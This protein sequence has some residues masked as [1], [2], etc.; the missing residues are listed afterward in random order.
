MSERKKPCPGQ[1][2]SQRGLTVNKM[3]VELG[4][5]PR[6]KS[7]GLQGAQLHAI[8]MTSPPL[9]ATLPAP[10]VSGNKWK[11]GFHQQHN[12]DFPFYVL[13]WKP[14]T[15][16]LLL[17]SLLSRTPEGR[18]CTRRLPLLICSRNGRAPPACQPFP[19]MFLLALARNQLASLRLLSSPVE[20]NLLELFA[21]PQHHA[22]QGEDIW[23]SKK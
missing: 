14:Q 10:I 1:G 15:M 13:L 3:E 23:I 22:R 8:P 6:T 18:L 20:S 17:L 4:A 11:C 19:R 2:N 9:R 21:F 7:L 16:A 12:H 5:N